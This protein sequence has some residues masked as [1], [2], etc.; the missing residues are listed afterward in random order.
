MSSPINTESKEWKDLLISLNGKLYERKEEIMNLGLISQEKKRTFTV[1]FE[2]R[3]F[4]NTLYQTKGDNGLIIFIHRFDGSA[5]DIKQAINAIRRSKFHYNFALDPIVDVK[6][7]DE[8]KPTI[9]SKPKLKEFQFGDKISPDDFTRKDKIFT[10]ES[11]ERIEEA[12]MDFIIDFNKV[13]YNS[14][15]KEEVKLALVPYVFDEANYLSFD[16]KSQVMFAQMIK[17]IACKDYDLFRKFYSAIER[18]PSGVTDNVKYPMV[19][20]FI[21]NSSFSSFFK[22]Q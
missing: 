19:L 10:E 5:D 14:F 16:P 22:K 3:D 4:I 6:T 18:I 8:V 13:C 21:D 1:N 7:Q 2:I 9:P 17:S 12:W 20:E 15:D 11:Q